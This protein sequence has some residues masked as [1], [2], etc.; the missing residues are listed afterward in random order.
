MNLPRPLYRRLSTEHRPLYKSLSSGH[1]SL[2]PR[3]RNQ[4][5]VH[6]PL[7]PEHRSLYRLRSPGHR[8]LCPR[9]SK[10]QNAHC[11]QH[12]VTSTTSGYT[13]TWF[14]MHSNARLHRTSHV[15]VYRGSLS[16][17]KMPIV[18]KMW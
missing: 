13:Y 14:H 3:Y 9:H 10:H 8:P 2:S 12:V 11:L 15:L 6:R 16:E 4:S 18:Y 17:I 5:P 7:S 1:R